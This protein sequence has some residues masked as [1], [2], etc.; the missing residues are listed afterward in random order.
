MSERVEKSIEKSFALKCVGCLQDDSASTPRLLR[1]RESHQIH[2]LP[3][4]GDFGTQIGRRRLRGLCWLRLRAQPL[5]RGRHKHSHSAAD[6][7]GESYEAEPKA[8]RGAA[9]NYMNFPRMRRDQLQSMHGRALR[10]KVH[11]GSHRGGTEAVTEAVTEAAYFYQ[12]I[13]TISRMEREKVHPS[14]L[15]LYF[16]N[17]A[18]IPTNNRPPL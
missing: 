8:L 16:I 12:R 4:S 6:Q 15:S 1:V 5:A 13:Q 2:V 7:A 14:M 9:K 18:I 17:F 3:G 11:R 10:K